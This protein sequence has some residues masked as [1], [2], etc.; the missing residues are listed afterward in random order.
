MRLL[1]SEFPG[2]VFA[3]GLENEYMLGNALL[4]APVMNAEGEVRA[5]IPSG[6][7]TDLFTYEKIQGPRYINRK[8]DNSTVPVFVR[9]N[10]IIATRT[11]D[12]AHDHS[13]LEGLTFTCFALADGQTAVC[14]VFEHGMAASG[15][16]N[17]TRAGSKITVQAQNFGKRKRIVFAGVNNIVSSSESVPEQTGYGTMISFTGNELIVTLG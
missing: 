11:P 5:Y 13:L 9:P 12:A 2:D 16:L 17:V 6:I 8:A 4:V 14:E 15:I 7:W 10:T 3:R 1:E